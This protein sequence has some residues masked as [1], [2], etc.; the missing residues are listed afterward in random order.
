M[1]LGKDNVSQSASLT[2]FSNELSPMLLRNLMQWLAHMA[3]I[4]PIS[5]LPMTYIFSQGRAVTLEA[6]VDSLDKICTMYK[7]E[8]SAQKTKLMTNDANRINMELYMK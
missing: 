8:I 6:L 5:G 7:M 4:L 3:G 1:E 2:S